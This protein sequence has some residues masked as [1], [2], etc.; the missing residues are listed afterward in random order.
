MATSEIA[1]E[2]FVYFFPIVENMKT[3]VYASIW[4]HTDKYGPLNQFNH[5]TELCDWEF[6]EFVTP[7]N[8]TLHVLQSLD[9]EPIVLSHPDYPTLDGKTVSLQGMC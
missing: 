6:T 3:L 5:D 4:P 9:G 2:A 7:N 8:D 1:A